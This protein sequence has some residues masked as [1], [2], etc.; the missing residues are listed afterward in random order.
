MMLLKIHV[1]AMRSKP[2]GSG[3][4]LNCRGL[5]AMAVNGLSPLIYNFHCIKQDT[6]VGVRRRR[7]DVFDRNWF[8]MIT[9]TP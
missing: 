9:E 3:D 6:F 7:R 4:S 8:V 5:K 2:S 1:R